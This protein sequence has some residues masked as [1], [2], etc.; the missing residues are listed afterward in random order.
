MKEMIEKL[1]H[2]FLYSAQLQD[3]EHVGCCK[4][5]ESG[6]G[7]LQDQVRGQIEKYHRYQDLIRHGTY[8][9]LTEEESPYDAWEFV[10]EDRTEVLVNLVITHLEANSAFPYVKLKGLDPEKQYLAEGATEPLSGAALMYGGYVFDA[11]RGDFPGTRVF[12]RC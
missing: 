4:V 6:D 8:Y 7:Q 10:S 1:G 9:R 3:Q 12:F 5:G 2:P 11:L